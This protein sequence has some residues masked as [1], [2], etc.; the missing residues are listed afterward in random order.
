MFKVTE[1]LFPVDFSDQTRSVAPFVSALRAHF[2]ANLTVIH[3]LQIPP[4]SYLPYGAHLVAELKKGLRKSAAVSMQEFVKQAFASL[5]VRSVIEDGDSARAIVEYAQKH[6]SDL[7]MLATHG[8]GPFRRFL[9]GSVTSKVLHDSST[10]VWTS[11]HTDAPPLDPH[12]YRTVLCAVDRG[13][14]S[15]PL[16]RWAKGLAESYG[17]TLGLVH[18]VHSAN[19]IAARRDEFG[20]WIREAGGESEILLPCGDIAGR[21]TETAQQENADLLVVGRGHIQRQLG[22][23]RTHSLEIIRQSPCPVVSV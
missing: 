18:V 14:S 13:A 20:T 17:A 4:Q 19:E 5:P 3:S 21:V 1:I 16:M 12:G 23:L 8:Y 15:V 2:G 22:G 10:P 11:V 7:I 9:I 6:G